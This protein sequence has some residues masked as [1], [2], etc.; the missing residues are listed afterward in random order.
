M[1]AGHNLALPFYRSAEQRPEVVALRVDGASYTYADL[2]RHAQS[3]SDWLWKQ[4]PQGPQRVVIL[5]GRSYES[6]AG[7]LGVCWSGA[8]YVPLN[9]RLPAAR[10]GQV[11][12]AIRPDAVLVDAEGETV[13]AGL[14][15]ASAWPAVRVGSI[16]KANGLC[17]P[18][19][20]D[21]EGTAY[22][23]FTSGSTGVPKGVAI[24]FRG[25]S[26]FL[27]AMAERY[28]LMPGDRVGQ[29]CELSFDISVSNI[30]TAWNSGASVYVVPAAQA[31]APRDFLRAEAINAWF[32]TPSVAVFL[33]QMKMLRPGVF[34]ALRYTMFGGD[35]LPAT[36]AERWVEAA[37]NGSLENIY[38][39]TEI[40][41][42]C[43]GVRYTGAETVTPGR[44]IVAIGTPFRGTELRILDEAGR[45]AQTGQ[46]GELV[47]GG[48]QVG[49]GYWDDPQLT[50]ARFP[51][52]DGKRWYRSGDVV[53][54]DASGLY[55]FL[56]RVDNQVKVRGFRVE[57]GEIEAHLREVCLSNAVVAVPW[58][59][60]LGSASGIVAFVSG[61]ERS[62]IEIQQALR[63]LL[64]AQSVPNQVRIVTH[65][66]VGLTGKIDRKALAAVLDGEN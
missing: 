42:A 12:E 29:P 63:N 47:I 16:E 33:E 51:V 19:T 34:P 15:G 59:M 22:I 1:A 46:P 21:S 60:R 32:S 24:A 20:V 28:P 64:P 2:G 4:A 41:V 13:L 40:T 8:A 30:F 18:V 11:L 38:G 58:P 17:G 55:H 26:C 62:G 45:E 52:L 10:L 50:E 48:P 7:L 9:P 6:Y 27:A 39:P 3:I 49:L 36:T 53:Y 65:L 31:M 54:R 14:P 43:T 37:P 61:T 57:L 25:V 56:S 35:G 23:L 66:P 5:G 44:G